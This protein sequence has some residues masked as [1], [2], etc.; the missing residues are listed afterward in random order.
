LDEGG[1]SIHSADTFTFRRITF[2]PVDF[3]AVLRDLSTRWIG[4]IGVRKF[5]IA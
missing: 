5:A 3:R 2:S 1:K 4:S